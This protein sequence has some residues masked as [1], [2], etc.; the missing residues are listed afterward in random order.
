[1]I[2]ML[3]NINNNFEEKL[4]KI[5]LIISIINLIFVIG[6]FC[7]FLVS[8]FSEIMNAEA[9]S[10][11]GWFI[12]ILPVFIGIYAFVC[13]PDILCLIF[14]I[15]IKK[16][17]K[18]LFPILNI[19]SAIIGFLIINSELYDDF[20]GGYEQ[21]YYINNIFKTLIV[22]CNIFLLTQFNKNNKIANNI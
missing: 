20:F 5:G 9:G 8:I 3:K 22:L 14:S 17:N 11:S 15:L 18:T 6:Y 19:I 1:M 10:A 2:N 16:E 7:F 21:V 12:F 13:I 4:K